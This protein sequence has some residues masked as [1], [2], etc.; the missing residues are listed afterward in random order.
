M[1]YIIVI[2]YTNESESVQDSMRSILEQIGNTL[3]ISKHAFVL[4][5]R[6]TIDAVAIREAIK[7]SAYETEQIFVSA[8]TIPAAWRNI[9]CDNSDL[10]D[11]LNEQD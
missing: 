6:R 3:Q 8:M 4:N 5:A 11:L 1:K 7:Q 9:M 2:E 10:K